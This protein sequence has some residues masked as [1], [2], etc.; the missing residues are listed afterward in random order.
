MPNLL[1]NIWMGFGVAVS[2][3]NLL[4]C[5]IGVVVGTFVGVLPGFGPTTTIALLLP[6]T[7]KLDPTAS[8][9]MLAGI[10]Y[11]AHH[12]GSTTAIILNMP[13]EPSSVVICL[14]GHPLARQGRAGPALC[15]AAISAFVAGCISI[16]LI[17]LF[18]PVLAAAAL[19]MGAPE[20]CAMVVLALIASSALSHGSFSKTMAMAAIGMLIGVVGTDVISGE[21]RFTFG[22]GQLADG[23]DLVPLAI[24]FFALAE[25]VARAGQTDIRRTVGKISGLIPTRTD[26]AASWR[27][28]LRGTGL[29]AVLGMLPGTGP[30][31][32]SFA[33]YSMERRLARDP[34]RFGCGAIEGVAGPEAADNAAALTHFVPMLTLGIPAGAPMALML[35]ALMIQGIAPGPLVM[36]QHADLFWGTIA[37][38]WIGNAILLVLNLP[39]VGLWVRLLTIPYRLLYPSVVVFCCIGAFSVRNSIFDVETAAAFG[40]AGYVFQVLDCHPAPLI[41]GFILGPIFEQNLR[42][43]LLISQGDLLALVLRPISGTILAVGVLIVLAQLYAA[44]RGRA[45]VDVLIAQR[46]GL[47][48]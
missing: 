1:A 34:S 29:G 6:L 15:I 28:I 45:P 14:D 4:F 41:L 21:R 9:I 20:Y 32:S 35:G 48:T 16:I 19:H 33:S 2:P 13:G 10:Y 37:S 12:A 22:N 44:W 43:G 25:I 5:L 27:S 31:I 40:I 46:D 24:G 23:I 17:T 42:R 18:S 3:D 38:M 11:G 36:V 26:L 30:M 8:L 7:F 47:D 39:M